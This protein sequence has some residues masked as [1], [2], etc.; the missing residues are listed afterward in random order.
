MNNFLEYIANRDFNE[1]KQRVVSILDVNLNSESDDIT[2]RKFSEFKN[3]KKLLTDPMIGSM[4]SEHPNRGALLT[5]IKDGNTT[6]GSFLGLLV[7]EDEFE[8]NENNNEPKVTYKVNGDDSFTV[9]IVMPN[10]RIIVH[11]NKNRRILEK[12]VKDR[13][14]N[15]HSKRTY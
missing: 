11:T 15:N 3:A 12:L 14:L 7:P 10:G 1:I 6:I 13:Y 2:S 4:I 9:R 8:E 5:A